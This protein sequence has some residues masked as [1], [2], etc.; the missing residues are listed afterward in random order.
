MNLKAWK[1]KIALNEAFLKFCVEDRLEILAR[2]W[3]KNDPSFALASFA[4]A[5]TSWGISGGN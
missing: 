3:R 4:A 5:S 2:S 1:N